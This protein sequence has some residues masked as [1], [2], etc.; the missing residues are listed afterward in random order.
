MMPT[1][2]VLN[3]LD[4]FAKQW[5]LLCRTEVGWECRRARPRRQFRT[6]CEIWFFENGGATLRY[7]RAL[8]RNISEQG[9]GLVT[10]C[11]VLQGVP[12]EIRI[13]T[14]GRPPTHLGGI[15]M[16]CRYTRR[17]F[18]EV[19]VSLRVFQNEPIFG[20]D[21]VSA[22]ART[23]WLQK[24][25][26]ELKIASGYPASGYSAGLYPASVYPAVGAVA[27]GT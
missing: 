17:S 18:H 22:V 8:T 14:P 3:E 7:Q 23:D 20:S 27:L 12:I 6:Q 21:P 15:V 25:L 24:T 13:E 11:V 10:K 2:V 9:I 19:G 26:R 16:F 1:Q 5:D 4:E